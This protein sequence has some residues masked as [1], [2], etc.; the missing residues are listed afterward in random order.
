MSAK[1]KPLSLDKELAVLRRLDSGQRQVNVANAFGIPAQSLSA[2]KGQRQA[3]AAASESALLGP[4]R[5]RLCTGYFSEVDDAV[6]TWVNDPET[7]R[8]QDP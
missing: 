5:K 2:I 4:A 1:R 7:F 6:A 3:I 8:F